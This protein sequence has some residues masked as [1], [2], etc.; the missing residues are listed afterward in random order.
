MKDYNKNKESLHV[1]YRDVNDLHGWAVSQKFPVNGSKWVD[2]FWEF[3]EDF[4]K[5][6]NE[7]KPPPTTKKNKSKK[8]T[9]SKNDFQKN[10]FKLMN[11]SVFKKLWK[12]KENMGTLNLLQQ[13]NVGTIWYPN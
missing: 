1:K 12:T 13:K 4:I 6:Y 9:R 11:N 10:F 8:K 7:K 5:S 3:N 2:K